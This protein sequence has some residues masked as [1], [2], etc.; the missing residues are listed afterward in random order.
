ME[1]RYYLLNEQKGNCWDNAVIESFLR[2]LKVE[3]VYQT[4][5]VD[6][7]FFTSVL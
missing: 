7:D 2:T 1:K 4:E 6:F 3:L 5:D